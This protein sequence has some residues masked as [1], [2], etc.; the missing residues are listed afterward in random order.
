VTVRR[1]YIETMEEILRRNPKVLVDTGL[2]NIVPL[3]NLDQGRGA[4][5]AASQ[6]M[7][8]QAPQPPPF[9]P[10]PPGSSITIRPQGIPR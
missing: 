8:Q 9:Q 3:L 7:R 6:G 2:Q 10:S 5:A 4:A 1:L